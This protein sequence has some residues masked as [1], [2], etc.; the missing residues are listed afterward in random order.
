MQPRKKLTDLAPVRKMIQNLRLPSQKQRENTIRPPASKRR[1]LG[2]SSLEEKV[3]RKAETKGERHCKRINQRGKEK[4]RQSN[5][6]EEVGDNVMSEAISLLT[7]KKGIEGEAEGH[8]GFVGTQ[9][10]A[11]HMFYVSQGKGGCCSK[12]EEKKKAGGSEN[13]EGMEQRGEVSP[14]SKELK[15][16]KDRAGPKRRE[17]RKTVPQC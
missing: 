9:E 6:R 3:S 10:T 15:E 8:K 13:L 4:A 2:E 5:T 16:G 12:P 7:R 17:L 1:S 14:E 11:R